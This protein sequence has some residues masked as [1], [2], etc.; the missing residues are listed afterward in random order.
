[1]KTLIISFMLVLTASANASTS[2]NNF[3]ATKH[4][5]IAGKKFIKC[6]TLEVKGDIRRPDFCIVKLESSAWDPNGVSYGIWDDANKVMGFR[7]GFI[8]PGP[9][10][11]ST[12]GNIGIKGYDYPIIK[13]GVKVSNL[14]GEI[15]YFNDPWFGDR[16]TIGT[17]TFQCR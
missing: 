12:G 2:C 1:M 5:L 7:G 13:F 6:E 9:Q 11:W 4:P 15:S 16:K 3:K 14:Y 10:E 17:A 8:S